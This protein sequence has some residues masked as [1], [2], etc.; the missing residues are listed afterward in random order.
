MSKLIT[1]DGLSLHLY[2]WLIEKP[3]ADVVFVHGFF[4]HAGRYENEAKFFNQNGYNFIAYDQRTHGRSEGKY[5][6]YIASFD[7]YIEDYKKFLAQLKLGIDR[8]YFLFAHSMGGLVL[9]SYL[10]NNK[11]PE[12]FKGAIFSAPFLMPDRNTAPI[13]QKLSG[14]IAAIAPKLKVLALDTNAISRDPNEIEKYI[15]DPLIYS[16]KLYASSGAQLIKQMNKIQAQFETFDV[17]FI[18]LHGSDDKV[19]EIEG[20]RLLYEKSKSIDKSLEIIKDS[21]HEITKD[22][23]KEKVLNLIVSWINKRN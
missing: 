9:C 8:P 1:K 7:N 11:P 19:A 20:S 16:D 4:E 23:D 12:N 10:L 13:L 5:R 3:K 6:S 2:N 18:I 17:P 15:N 22:L 21:K 14:F